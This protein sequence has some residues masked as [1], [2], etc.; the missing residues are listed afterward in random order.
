MSADVSEQARYL[1]SDAGVARLAYRALT[2]DARGNQWWVDVDAETGKLLARAPV[3]M[4]LDS[5][6]DDFYW[7]MPAWTWVGNDGAGDPIH[8][9]ALVAALTETAYYPKGNELPGIRMQ[10]NLAGPAERMRNPVL[11]LTSI[12]WLGRTML[13]LLSQWPKLTWDDLSSLIPQHAGFAHCPS[14]TYEPPK[15]FSGFVP[16]GAA[17]RDQHHFLQ[18]AMQDIED[19]FGWHGLNNQNNPLLLV[20]NVNPQFAC[21]AH[22]PKSNKFHFGLISCGLDG[23]GLPNQR[24]PP[25]EV[26][27]HEFGHTIINDLGLHAVDF[28]S[29]VVVEAIADIFGVSVKARHGGDRWLVADRP[30]FMQRYKEWFCMTVA[31]AYCDNP[32]PPAV[33]DLAHPKTNNPLDPGAEHYLGDH[34]NVNLSGSTIENPHGSSQV[35]SHMLYRVAEGAV[36]GARDGNAAKGTYEAFAGIGLQEMLDIFHTS[37]GALP[38]V[39]DADWRLDEYA[40]QFRI[41]AVMQCGQWSEADLVSGKTAWIANLGDDVDLEAAGYVTPQWDQQDAFSLT[42][43]QFNGEAAQAYEFQVAADAGFTNIVHEDSIS[44]NPVGD[45]RFVLKLAPDADHWW[46][47]RLANAPM[48]S[49]PWVIDREACWRPASPFRTGPPAQVTNPKPAGQTSATGDEVEPWNV[50]FGWTGDQ[51]F[52]GYEF[53]VDFEEPEGG[54]RYQ[55]VLAHKFFEI[56]GSWPIDV[57]NP[58]SKELPNFKVRPIPLPKSSHLCWKIIPFAYDEEG[59]RIDGDALEQCFRTSEPKTLITYPAPP[60]IDGTLS[61]VPAQPLAI[62][63]NPADGAEQH[64]FSLEVLTLSEANAP[65][66][67]GPWAYVDDVTTDEKN[68]VKEEEN[69]SDWDARTR[70]RML[71]VQL[72]ASP[73]LNFGLGKVRATI[74]SRSPLISSNENHGGTYP[75]FHEF[76]QP[77]I[78]DFHPVD[79][80]D[81]VALHPFVTAPY[82]AGTCSSKDST[83]LSV[84]WNHGPDA[85]PDKV[86]MYHLK[87]YPQYC[88]NGTPSG[89]H[90]IG[91]LLDPDFADTLAFERTVEHN[92]KP[93]QRVEF[94]RG[95]L[96]L[97]ED[98]EMGNVEGFLAHLYGVSGPEPGPAGLNITGNVRV[99]LPVLPATL[100][101]LVTFEDGGVEHPEWSKFTFFKLTNKNPNNTPRTDQFDPPQHDIKIRTY[102]GATCDENQVITEVSGSFFLDLDDVGQPDNPQPQV[103]ARSIMTAD[104]MLCPRIIGDCVSATGIDR[105]STPKTPSGLVPQEAAGH[106]GASWNVSG[107]ANPETL[108]Y[109]LG[110]V[111]QGNQAENLLVN[112]PAPILITTSMLETFGDQIG[113][114]ALAGLDPADAG[115]AVILRLMVCRAGTD[116]CSDEITASYTIGSGPADGPPPGAPMDIALH[117]EESGALGALIGEDLGVEAG[118]ISVSWNPPAGAV[119][120]SHYLITFSTTDTVPGVLPNWL[121]TLGVQG[122]NYPADPLQYTAVVRALPEGVALS[123]T[124][125][126]Q[127]VWLLAETHLSPPP[128]TDTWL[129][130]KVWAC[131]GNPPLPA[132]RNYDWIIGASTG[133]CSAPAEVSLQYQ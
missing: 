20:Q 73:Y 33:R 52:R 72:D 11:G 21:S 29:K 2:V 104:A 18:V 9:D 36:A 55:N 47:V 97:D 80:A 88:G 102:R 70:L 24:I 56:D 15:G 115:K 111:A 40:K 84:E 77:A 32:P 8:C 6:P 46:R 107:D 27:A 7:T 34:W 63:Y 79:P 94:S 67:E 78:V 62:D 121:N 65:A 42:E 30:A 125:W 19:R 96:F 17:D 83:D 95:E 39:N 58:G 89:C 87:L 14:G 3:A 101:T 61:K 59:E 110:L 74:K 35:V 66:A 41:A 118:W 123:G 86:E 103:S 38:Q 16:Y 43:F 10:V 12:Q 69:P 50:V 120:P 117:Q 13:E 133:N 22:T 131:T 28:E 105:H 68:T 54:P 48:L 108:E 64:E 130:A 127:F 26:F 91:D 5:A 25:I 119:A 124:N 1:R 81:F 129:T 92:G 44:T 126:A 112:H 51:R 23:P 82:A 49:S 76:A 128:A 57:E 4:H 106:L 90:P 109:H 122:V 60:S 132:L 37:L 99:D 98:D 100:G 53:W 116:R 45:G 93:S 114:H 85:T 75:E 113:I 31:D 71:P